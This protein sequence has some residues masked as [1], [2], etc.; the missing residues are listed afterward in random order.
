MIRID[1]ESV[2]DL[3]EHALIVPARE[4]AVDRFPGA[5]SL[6]QISPGHARF[7]DEDD[8]VHEA[9]VG[10]L[11]RPT[12]PAALWRQQT[13]EANPVGFGQLVSAHRKGRS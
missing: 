4:A 12:W 10:Q 7:R 11:R 13:F 3:L 8:R 9:T 2:E 5:E 6:G 1:G